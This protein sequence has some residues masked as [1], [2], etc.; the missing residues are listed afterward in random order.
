MI[1]ADYFPRN[2]ASLARDGRLVFIAFL[3]GTTVEHANLA[4]I[5]MKRL[6]VTGSTMRPRTAGE[7]AAIAAALHAHA[8]P[9]L[10]SGRVAPVISD[11]FPL[12]DAADA[13]RRMESSAHIGKI[14]LKVAD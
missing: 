3:G 14:V 4:P 5:M 8:W 9:L 6:T 2:I 13:H 1:G 10:V 7:K 11:V 12:A